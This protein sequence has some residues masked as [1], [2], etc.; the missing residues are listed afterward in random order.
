MRLAVLALLLAAHAL[1]QVS[2]PGFETGEVGLVPAGWF[3][4]RVASD[5]GFGVKLVDQGCRTGVRCAMLTGSTNHPRNIFGNIMQMISADGYKLRRIRL[6]S[7]I[8]VEGANT[9]A[10]MWLRLDR[11][12]HSMAFLENMQNQPVTSPEWQTY[13][14]GT[15]VPADVSR[16]AFGIML[17]GGGTAWVDDVSLDVLGEI[18]EDMVEPPRFLS[19]RALP[20][21][22]AFARLYGYVRF[23]HP[24]GQ[25][26]NTDWDTFAIEGVR[27]AESPASDAE[28]AARLQKLFQPLAP[29]RQVF[30][31]GSRP[32]PAALGKGPQVI[33]YRH[34]GLGL[35]AAASPY[36]VYRS[37]RE[38]T[39]ATGALPPPFEAE[40]APGVIVRVPLALY[41]GTGSCE[42][43][44]H[45]RCVLFQSS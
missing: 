24:S 2:T 7:A 25:A 8:R 36:Q 13:D 38:R 26:A 16:I 15:T 17:F 3:Q 34:H 33:R 5:A 32:Q 39:P 14:I 41:T 10:Q 44:K 4:P 30:L 35:L 19:T 42:I 21:L 20:N 43:I 27:S 23:F 28:L 11:A 40:V 31:A 9:R 12:D 37:T 45:F 6:R 1:A 29:T 18:R 22:I